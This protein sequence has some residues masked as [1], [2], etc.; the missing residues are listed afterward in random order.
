MRFTYALNSVKLKADI[1]RRQGGKDF[2]LLNMLIKIREYDVI[3]TSNI[4]KFN[5]LSFLIKKCVFCTWAVNFIKTHTG[6]L[7]HDLNFGGWVVAGSE[8]SACAT[9]PT[10]PP[11]L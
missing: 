3:L 1:S 4:H 9:L 8:D 7:V 6:A 5:F 10:T 2:V 11:P